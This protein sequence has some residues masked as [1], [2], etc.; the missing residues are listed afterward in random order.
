MYDIFEN[1]TTAILDFKI[2]HFGRPVMLT[3]FQ[4]GADLFPGFL[5]EA[6]NLALQLDLFF[7]LDNL[8]F[9]RRETPAE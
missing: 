1:F 7:L 3:V 9:W 6:Q 4:L 5:K 8:Q 2:E